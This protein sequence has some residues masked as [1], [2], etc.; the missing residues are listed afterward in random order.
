MPV[1]IVHIDGVDSQVWQVHDRSMATV[2][3]VLNNVGIPIR[4]SRRD[5]GLVARKEYNMPCKGKKK[6]KK[7]SKKK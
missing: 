3:A 1:S 5:Q 2:I 4:T 6:A 7:K